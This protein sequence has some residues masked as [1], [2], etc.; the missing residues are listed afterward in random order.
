MK[1]ISLKNIAVVLIVVFFTLTVTN[2]GSKGKGSDYNGV[3]EYTISSDDN[4]VIDY[5]ITSDAWAQECAIEPMEGRIIIDLGSPDLCSPI[6]VGNCLGQADPVFVI[7]SIPADI[8]DITLQSYDDHSGKPDQVQLTERYFL[9][10]FNSA[11]NKIVDTNSIDD[12]PDGVGNDNM[13]QLVNINLFVEDDID[14]IAAIHYCDDSNGNICDSS[15]NSIVPVCVAFDLIEK[16]GGDGCTPGYWKQ[17]HHFDSWTAPLTPDTLFSDMFGSDVFGD[18]TLLDVLKQGGGKVKALGRHAVAALL[19]A[20]SPDVSFDRS[21]TQVK[22][23]FNNAL[24]DGN[25]E[26][27]KNTFEGF[28]EQGCPLN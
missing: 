11:D 28:N 14:S 9:R 21:T 3:N 13:T 6:E 7:P 10:L 26:E 19:N 18:M 23:M 5:K 25:I 15:A 8:Y 1:G 20:N 16:F 22:M 24:S 12:L 2:C 27:V 17:S 4:R